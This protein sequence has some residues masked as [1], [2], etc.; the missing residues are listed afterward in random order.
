MLTATFSCFDGLSESG[1]FRLWQQGVLSWS[2]FESGENFKL[3]PRKTESIRQQIPGAR[4]ALEAGIAD[5][6]LNRLN[7]RAKVRVYPHFRDGI[8]FLDIETTGLGPAAEVTTIAIYSGKRLSVFVEGINLHEF[9][10]ILKGAELLVTFNGQRF[11]LPI[12]RKRF[13]MG[14]GLPHLD[15][16]PVA[17]ANG[18]HGGLKACEKKMKLK[19]QVGDDLDG[20]EAVRL[21][22]R[23]QNFNDLE[24]LRLLLAYNC[25]DALSL[26][27]ILM[28]LYNDEMCRH[29]LF[30]KM[31]PGIN[32]DVWEPFR[33][34]T[35]E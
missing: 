19:R 28:R 35:I 1:E 20:R 8:R 33:S 4:V 3:S 16:L 30:M 24:A 31:T 5:W 26:E 9:P 7:S 25:Q 32:P 18:Y 21:W 22:K 11:D 12:L 29:P 2:D 34:L 27:R 6:F 23:Y 14:L 10:K 13:K 15:L 17:K